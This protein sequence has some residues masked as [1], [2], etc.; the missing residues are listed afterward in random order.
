[1]VVWPTFLSS[2]CEHRDCEY[3]V[4]F[5]QSRIWEIGLLCSVVFMYQICLRLKV[6]SYNLQYIPPF[7]STA[8]KVV[9]MSL[10]VALCTSGDS[11]IFG[12]WA[13]HFFFC[14]F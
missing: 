5:V 2:H 4:G 9:G 14:A 3:L 6:I 11:S 7:K 1:V 10:M 8:Y 12:V 13:L